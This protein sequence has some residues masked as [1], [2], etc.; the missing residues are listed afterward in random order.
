MLKFIS[1]FV[2]KWYGRTS[3]TTCYGSVGSVRY[4][5]ATVQKLTSVNVYML[6]IFHILHILIN[7]ENILCA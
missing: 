5:L 6:K 1:Y 2:K 4:P 3:H 7:C